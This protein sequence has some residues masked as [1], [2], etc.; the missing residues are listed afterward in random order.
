MGRTIAI[1]GEEYEEI[2]GESFA[3]SKAVVDM[4]IKLGRPQTPFT[5][6]GTK[7][8]NLIIAVWEDLYPRDRIQ[9][10]AERT[11]YKLNEKS[12]GEQVRTHTGRSLASYPYPIFAMM[13]AVFKGFDPAKRENCMKMVQIWP[14]FMFANKR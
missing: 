14:M 5:E 4:W 7:I 10:L 3:A 8:M 12:I 11:E 9:W 6:A 2:P 1:K 13:Q